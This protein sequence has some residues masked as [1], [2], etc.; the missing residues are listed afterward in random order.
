MR[1]V[2]RMTE[3]FGGESRSIRII[4]DCLDKKLEGRNH[5]DA[6]VS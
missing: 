5:I 3:I 4:K 2:V 1:M 6:N